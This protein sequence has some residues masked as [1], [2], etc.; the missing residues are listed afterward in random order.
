MMKLTKYKEVL[1]AGK[2]G[3][4]KILAP[5]RVARAKKQAELE[6][7]K[8]DETIAKTEAVVH[9]LLTQEEI[10]FN[11]LISYL[12]DIS[13]AERRKK[14]FDQIIKELFD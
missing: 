7:L 6:Q 9:E 10:N 4:K 2:E 14:Q 8:I 11:K 5:V 12:D 13:I 3:L 1:L